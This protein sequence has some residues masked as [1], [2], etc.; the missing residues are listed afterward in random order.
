MLLVKY[1]YN[2]TFSFD[3]IIPLRISQSVRIVWRDDSIVMQMMETSFA[4]FSDN[5]L[6][7][8]SLKSS[9][10]FFHSIRKNSIIGIKGKRSRNDRYWANVFVIVLTVISS[11]L[12]LIENFSLFSVD[13][14]ILERLLHDNCF[15]DSSRQGL[16]QEFGLWFMDFQL[17]L[18]TE[19]DSGL[20]TAPLHH[21]GYSP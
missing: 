2:K 6:D 21:K 7:M 1:T 16:A 5:F 12:E 15:M 20:P 18:W 4:S 17:L 10:S 13:G 11:P 14:R 9:S 8:S 3:L 19:D